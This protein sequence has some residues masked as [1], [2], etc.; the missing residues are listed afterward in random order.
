M[1]NY[2]VGNEYPWIIIAQGRDPITR[3]WPNKR[4]SGTRRRQTRNTPGTRARW[5]RRRPA[6][7]QRQNWNPPVTRRRRNCNPPG[8]RLRPN[9]RLPGTRPGGRLHRAWPGQTIAGRLLPATLALLGLQKPKENLY[10]YT[11]T[12]IPSLF[13]LF[14]WFWEMAISRIHGGGGRS[15]QSS[16]FI[17]WRQ[18][19]IFFF[20]WAPRALSPVG[21][22]FFWNQ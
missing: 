7:R 8:T 5:I 11:L 18:G 12:T 17:V 10:S 9:G 15:G 1:D 3:F 14:F 16:R 19:S 13:P 21:R 6:T 2:W 22:K 20:F 4:L